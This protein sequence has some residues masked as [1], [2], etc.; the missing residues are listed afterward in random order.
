MM[1][2]MVAKNAKPK[3]KAQLCEHRNKQ[4]MQSQPMVLLSPRLTFFFLHQMH[5]LCVNCLFNGL[6]VGW[7]MLIVGWLLVI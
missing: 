2:N 1:K 4:R 3:K 5:D 7:L 6:I